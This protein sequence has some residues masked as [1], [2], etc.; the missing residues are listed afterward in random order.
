MPCAVI[1]ADG[2]LWVVWSRGQIGKGDLFAMR[3]DQM[4]QWG[5]PRQLTASDKDDR[6]PFALAGPDTTIYTFWGSDRSGSMRIYN[7]RF[8]TAV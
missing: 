8:V 3:R 5:T 2:V 7:K 4:G 1:D 6:T